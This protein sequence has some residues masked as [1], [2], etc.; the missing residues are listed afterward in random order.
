MW[1]YNSVAKWNSCKSICNT[2]WG[3]S[4]ER[5]LFFLIFVTTWEQL[6][7]VENKWLPS[8]TSLYISSSRISLN[9]NCVRVLPQ[10]MV[11]SASQ[12]LYVKTKSS[13]K[14][15]VFPHQNGLCTFSSFS[16]KKRNTMKIEHR[17]KENT[18]NKW[19]KQFDIKVGPVI[20]YTSIYC[21]RQSYRKSKQNNDP[22]QQRKFK[23]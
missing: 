11:K 17:K 21:F 1:N 20:L 3:M 7:F 5:C 12:L 23:F 2:V 9:A 18:K 16:N 19:K 22:K 13:G 4:G 8:S 15:G 10:C 6:F 14:L